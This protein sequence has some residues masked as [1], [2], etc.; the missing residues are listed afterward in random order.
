MR[1]FEHLTHHGQIKRGKLI[2][3]NPKWLRGMVQQYDDA[4]VVVVIERKRKSKS[5]EQS[6]YYWAVVLQYISEHTGH[7]SEDLHDIF[8]AKYLRRKKRWRGKD[9]VTLASTNELSVGEMAEYI[10]N[11]ILEANDLGIEVPPPD[12]LYQFK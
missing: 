2:L 9:M 11:V 8:K 7:S 6:G 5:K 12:P 4:P 3:D 1:K 10:T